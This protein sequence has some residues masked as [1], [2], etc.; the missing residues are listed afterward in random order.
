MAGAAV[1]KAT[2]TLVSAAQQAS[3]RVDEEE[4]F[5]KPKVSG[6]VMTG[7]RQELE[8]Q[9]EIARRQRELEKAKEQLFKIR[10]E[11]AGH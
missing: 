7:F 6:K 5:M 11:R 2:E 8:I 10:R 4:Q 1:R 9:E 3:Q